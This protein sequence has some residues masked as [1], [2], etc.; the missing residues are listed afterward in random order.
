MTSIKS[1]LAYLVLSSLIFLVGC[2]TWRSECG[3]EILVEN[4]I[5]DTTLHVGG[6]SFFRDLFEP[7]VVFRQTEGKIITFVATSTDGGIIVSA[8]G[9]RNSEGRIT[10]LEVIPRSEGETDV[11]IMA[12]DGCG[13][14]ETSFNVTVLDTTQQKF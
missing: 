7:P 2:E 11:I 6:E 9:R 1:I 10:I 12:E 13:E 3:G 4:P 8:N 14:K 5:P